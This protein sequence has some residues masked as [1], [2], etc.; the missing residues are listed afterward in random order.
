MCSCEIIK[1]KQKQIIKVKKNIRN[2]FSG[3]Y[4][5]I[6]LKFLKY[7]G[8]VRVSIFPSTSIDLLAFQMIIWPIWQCTQKNFAQI[9]SIFLLVPIFS[10]I[11]LVVFVENN[12]CSVDRGKNLLEFKWKRRRGYENCKN[13]LHE[14]RHT[15]LPLS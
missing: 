4:F 14:K 13:S 6:S 12:F 7:D 15:A 8:P 5:Q 9:D 2:C 11:S 3:I 10:I 1:K